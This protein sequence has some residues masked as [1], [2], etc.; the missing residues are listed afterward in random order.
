MEDQIK[1]NDLAADINIVQINLVKSII[2]NSAEYLYDSSDRTNGFDVKIDQKTYFNHEQ[3]SLIQGLL[4]QLSKKNRPSEATGYDAIFEIQITYEIKKFQNYYTLQD[5]GDYQYD[6]MFGVTIA[7]IGYSTARGII[8]NAT[9]GSV[10]NPM[11]VLLPI[12]SPSTL[13]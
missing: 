9:R 4:V 6:W 5:D 8:W 3:Q 13:L 1:D 10:L 7:G 2:D 11:G 12:V